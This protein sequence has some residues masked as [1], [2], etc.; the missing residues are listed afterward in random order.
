MNERDSQAQGQPN[1]QEG[2]CSRVFKAFPYSTMIA[3]LSCA[4]G[5]GLF[6]AENHVLEYQV[7]GQV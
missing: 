4:V 5:G 3:C 2:K 7:T 6:A 1:G